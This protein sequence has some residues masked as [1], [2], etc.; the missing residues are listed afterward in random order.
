M[1]GN[2]EKRVV[3]INCADDALRE[4]RGLSRRIVTFSGFS[5]AG[6]EQEATVLALLSTKFHT[7]NP[8][9][10]IVCSGA[11]A[12]GI[13]AVYRLAAKRRFQT[14]G[15]VSSVAE[16]EQVSFANDV[17]IVFVIE[18]ETWGGYIDGTRTPSP[19][20]RVMI[21]ASDQLIFIGGGD[22]A[23]DEY[24]Y[25]VESHKPVSF[26]AADMNHSAAIEKA[27]RKEKPAPTEFGGALAEYLAQRD[28]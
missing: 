16:R 12:A 20:S 14:I 3:R 2:N 7:L 25:A 9:T 19:T 18:D 26:D 1:T 10:D 11:T 5:A 23:R 17:G 13:G 22:V 6:Y 4:I 24:E 27:R 21:E 28:S 8:A 15:I